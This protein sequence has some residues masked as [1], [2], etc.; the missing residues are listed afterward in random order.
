MFAREG[1]LGAVPDLRAFAISLLGDVDCADDFVQETLVRAMADIDL[2]EADTNMRIW[3]FTILRNLIRTKGRRRRREAED[4][5]RRYANGLKSPLKQYNLVD[6][7][8]FRAALGKL[9]AHQREALLLIGASGFS[10]QHAAE[11]CDCA[12]GTV[13]SRAYRARSHLAKLLS[14]EIADEFDA[15]YSAPAASAV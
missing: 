13:K 4:I 15:V 6:I 14:N 1:M 10:Y 2:L 12:V 8:E 3:L 11:I 9:P 5:H 7:E